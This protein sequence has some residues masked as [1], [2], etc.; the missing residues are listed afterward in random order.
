LDEAGEPRHVIA[1]RLRRGQAVPG[2]GHVL[3]PDGDPRAP[4]LVELCP[5]GAE[6]TRALAFAEAALEL[7]GQR[8]TLDFGLV[9]LARALRLPQNAPFVLFAIGRS[10]GWIAHVI[11]Q[12][13]LPEP[14]RPR[15]EY[16]GAAPE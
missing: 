12:Y 1:E 4:R 15:A 16:V 14:I 3:Y 13:A 7:L 6:K 8:P 5:A 2:F 11:E 10:A 9:A